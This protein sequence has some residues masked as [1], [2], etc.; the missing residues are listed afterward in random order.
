MRWNKSGY[1]S[2]NTALYDHITVLSFVFYV[3]LF[4]LILGEAPYITKIIAE[5]T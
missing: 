3:L 4:C 2:Y 1:I 5:E